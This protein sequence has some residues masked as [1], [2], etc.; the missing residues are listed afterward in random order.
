MINKKLTNKDLDENN[1]IIKATMRSVR[2]SD[3]KIRP[4]IRNIKG[5]D[6]NV[7]ISM[8]SVQKMKTSY[9]LLKL[10]KSITSNIKNANP[11][12]KNIHIKN[13]Y[14]DQGRSYKRVFARSQGRVNYIRR[15]TSH[16]TIII[17]LRNNH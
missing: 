10:I 1:F 12:L 9:F 14:V 11:D 7:V 13:L 16:I 15:K 2:M 3:K 8:L 17:L 5:K 6:L 4:L